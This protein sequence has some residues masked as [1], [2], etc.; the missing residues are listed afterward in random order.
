LHALMSRHMNRD[1]LRMSLD[2]LGLDGQEMIARLAALQPQ[3]SS[4]EARHLLF[5]QTLL[6]EHLRRHGYPK[7]IL[8]QQACQLDDFARSLIHLGG[9]AIAGTVPYLPE[10]FDPEIDVRRTIQIYEDVLENIATTTIDDLLG[11]RI[12]SK[13]WSEPFV[14]FVHPCIEELSMTLYYFYVRGGRRLK[15]EFILPGGNTPVIRRAQR[16]CAL[17]PLLIA[18]QNA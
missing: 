5:A 8:P 16:S 13:Q 17:V 14:Q 9:A 18:C 15:R 3:A 12:I 2:D 1:I 11:M 7:L 10:P 6:N 4:I